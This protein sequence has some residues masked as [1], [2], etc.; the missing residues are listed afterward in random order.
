MGDVIELVPVGAWMES[1]ICDFV[2]YKSGDHRVNLTEEGF[3]KKE[4]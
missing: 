1:P 2:P 4:G 3:R